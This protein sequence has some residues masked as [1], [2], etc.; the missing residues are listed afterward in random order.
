MKT[1]GLAG[2]GDG[3]SCGLRLDPEL[4]I[5]DWPLVSDA[6]A[7]V[8]LCIFL[9]VCSGTGAIAAMEGTDGR[10][11]WTPVPEEYC[12]AEDQSAAYV[13]P[14]AP[15]THYSTWSPS[16]TSPS[17]TS[18][19]R[20]LSPRT[21]NPPHTH[22]PPPAFLLLLSAVSSPDPLL[23]HVYHLQSEKKGKK[24]TGPTAPQIL[25]VA[26]WSAEETEGLWSDESGEE[27]TAKCIKNLYA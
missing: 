6:C 19:P 13:P 15:V 24:K 1:C 14:W 27:R 8:C 23:R 4:Q 25:H 12:G 10:G 26:F 5:T 3:A 11:K 20:H 18:P 16:S 7:C 9:H 21:D 22:T 17:W 2:A